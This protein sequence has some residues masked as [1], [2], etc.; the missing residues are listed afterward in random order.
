M[1]RTNVVQHQS[2]K[3]HLKVGELYDDYDPTDKKGMKRNKSRRSSTGYLR[4]HSRP[5]SEDTDGLIANMQVQQEDQTEVE[6][7]VSKAT[8]THTHTQIQI[9]THTRMHARTHTHIYTQTQTHTYIQTDRHTYTHRQTDTHLVLIYS[10]R[11]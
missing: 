5:L 9:H 2:M 7:T 8:H 3:E 4:R 1:M 10:C 6:I 11:Q